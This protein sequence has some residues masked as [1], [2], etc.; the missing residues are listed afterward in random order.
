MRPDPTAVP[1]VLPPPGRRR[2][3]PLVSP[4][5]FDFWAA[6]VAPT[7]TWN[8]PLGRILAREPAAADAVS[9][10][11]KPNRHFRGFAP[12]QHL[13][14]GVEVDGRRLVRSYSP[15]AA[16]GK[17]GCFRITVKKIE[18]GRVSAHLCDRA[19]A[20]DVLGLGEAFGDLALPPGDGLPRLLLA[21]GSGITP[22]MALF[23][24]LA[25]QA[26]PGPTTLLYFTRRR[27]QRCF[28]DALRA[29]AARHVS[30]DV[31]FVLTRDSAEADDEST[32]R[33]NADQLATWRGT[34]AHV[35]ACGPD[36]FVATARE[37]LAGTAASFA[38]ESFSPPV[39]DTRD[40]GSVALT[41]TRSG[42]TLQ[43]PRGQ[44]LLD[45]L[46]AA[47]LS[48]ASGCRRGLCNTCACAKSAGSTRHLL[49]GD[50][51]H[52]PVSALR[53]CVSSAR[54]DLVLDL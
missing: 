14:I 39:A 41:L 33:L 43:V 26:D 27:E 51:E 48:P 19:K 38:A 21:A 44:S 37:L 11:I 53:L 22:M 23:A 30:L 18:G 4:A 32:G 17:D 28:V 45:A 15:Q 52:E 31:R 8:R 49:T 54:S 12:G 35:L 25:A 10:L 29:I 6:R 34:P 3:A 24:D 2:R 47:G 46:E 20:G 13:N 1:P 5:L 40:S 42:Q 50:V 9:L 36:G 16:P 7:W